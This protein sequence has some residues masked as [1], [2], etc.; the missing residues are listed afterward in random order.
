MLHIYHASAGSGKTYTLA[1]YYICLALKSPDYFIKI[2]AV[3]FTNKSTEE[4]KNRIL[5]NLFHL[6]QG[7]EKKLLSDV[8]FHCKLKETEVVAISKEVLTKIL[9]NY[10]Q[11]SIFTID[12]FFQKIIKS[13]A[14]EIGLESHTTIEVDSDKILDAI[15]EKIIAKLGNKDFFPTEWLVDFAIQKLEEGKSWNIRKDIQNFGQDIFK[16]RFKKI[17]ENIVSF[18]FEEYNNYKKHLQKSIVFFE[19][20]IEKIVADSLSIIHKK[21]LTIDDFN[22][23]KRGPIGLFLLFESKDYTITQSRRDA[24]NKRES[25]ITKNKELFI[26]QKI[27]EAMDDGLM[28]NYTAIIDFVD[29]EGKHYFTA[30]IIM[31]NIYTLGITQYLIQEVRDYVS[32]E[33]LMLISDTSDFLKKIIEEN[34]AHYIYEKTGNAYS[35]FLIDEFQDT[36]AFQWNNFKPLLTNSISQGFENLIVGDT[37]QAIYRWRGSE[38]NLLQKKIH[39]DFYNTQTKILPFNYRSSPIIVNFNNCFFENVMKHINILHE[40]NRAELSDIYKDVN[41]KSTQS[42]A[43][44]VEICLVE[45]QKKNSNDT[46]SEEHIISE[47]IAIIEK[48]QESGGTLKDICILVRKSSEAKIISDALLLKQSHNEGTYVYDFISPESLQVSN[49]LSVMLLISAL[50][51]I[52]NPKDI[53]SKNE[54]I[55]FYFTLQYSQTKKASDIFTQ[56]YSHTIPLEY[57]ENLKA[58]SFIPLI[59]LTETL[60][61]IFHLDTINAE[62]PYIL[63]FQDA[64]LEF[65]KKK[66]GEI[67]SF[68]EW[69]EETKNKHVVRISEE[70][71]AI[72]IMTIHKSKGLEFSSVIIPFCHWKLDTDKYNQIIWCSN[73]EKTNVPKPSFV[74]VLYN[75]SLQQTFMDT[76]YE[77][78]L[79]NN[80]LDNIN[81]LYVAFTRAKQNL[82]IL[83]NINSQKENMYTEIKTSADL[84]YSVFFSSKNTVLD[85]IQLKK[86]NFIH[87]FSYG[88]L[89]YIKNTELKSS[90]K[91]ILLQHYISHE[92]KNK[93]LLKKQ[94]RF[95]EE[96]TNILSQTKM[97]FLYSTLLKKIKNKKEIDFHIQKLSLKENISQAEKEEISNHINALFEKEMTQNWFSGEWN[98]KTNIEFLNPYNST[99]KKLDTL[100]T[101]KEDAILIEYTINK[102]TNIPHHHNSYQYIPKILQNFGYKNIFIYTIYIQEGEIQRIL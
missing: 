51:Y 77:E 18:G 46:D 83:G 16:E 86:E 24:I 68:L 69:W 75:A 10:G 91:S 71:N 59:N 1:F 52:Y 47:T 30:K 43:G 62:Y 76:Q 97:F 12:K 93:L 50:K 17:Q 33:N 94:T 101:K 87:S 45:K 57:T 20:H 44:V 37:K 88:N 67:G 22:N 48:I 82:F 28:N 2:L 60:I 80:Y 55:S 95:L 15:L 53:L 90:T 96:K 36:S 92:W 29:R 5:K 81:I 78:E 4:M 49:S 11:F 54:F 32:Q 98:I 99:Y 14:K 27:E 7:K 100:L 19:S 8:A 26:K 42:T 58:L 72:K 102:K 6:S 89:S 85:N 63:S 3:T 84:L 56:D 79:K 9:H 25:F 61:K 31:R 66:G 34:D 13:F 65:H 74:P 40:K 73:E 35:H 41:Q 70:Q 38:I 64:V 39:Q 23:G 21:G